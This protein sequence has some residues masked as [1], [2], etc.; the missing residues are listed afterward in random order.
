LVLRIGLVD[1]ILPCNPLRTL[2]ILENGS[3]IES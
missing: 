1:G 2:A 3:V